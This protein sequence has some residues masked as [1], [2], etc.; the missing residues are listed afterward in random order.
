VPLKNVALPEGPWKKGAVDIVGPI[1]DKYIVT[2]ID[3][4]SS[5]PEAVVVTDISS[6]NIIR[7][8]SLIFSRFGYPEEIVSDNGKQFV[9]S[10]FQIFL[11]SCGIKRV[12]CSPY[13]PRSNGKI[14]RF[15]RYLKKNLKSVIAEGKSWEDSMSQILMSYRSTPSFRKR[16]NSS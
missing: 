12:R 13:Y 7:V 10:K 4:Y 8:L 3:Y 6:Q 15:H 16:Q 11:K 5:Y 2:Y 9:S 1:D 14:E